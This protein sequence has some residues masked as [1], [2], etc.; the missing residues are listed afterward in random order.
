MNKAQFNKKVLRHAFNTKIDFDDWLKNNDA[1]L[2]SYRR[3]WERGCDDKE[4]KDKEKSL[5]TL[6]DI[7]YKLHSAYRDLQNALDDMFDL[8]YSGARIPGKAL[9]KHEFK[10]LAIDFILD[11]SD[12]LDS[13]YVL[14]ED[15][16]E[17]LED[18]LDESERKDWDKAWEKYTEAFGDLE[19]YHDDIE[20]VL[21]TMFEPYVSDDPED[22]DDEE[23]LDSE[24]DEEEDDELDDASLRELAEEV[25]AKEERM[26]SRR[27]RTSSS[28]SP[29]SRSNPDSIVEA[30]R[31]YLRTNHLNPHTEQ[32][33]QDIAR[34][35]IAKGIL[36]DSEAEICALGEEY[37]RRHG[38][39]WS[40]YYTPAAGG[41][42]TPRT[43]LKDHP[44]I[45]SIIR[46][47]PLFL[48]HNP[49][50]TRSL[51]NDS[52]MKSRIQS[53]LDDDSLLAGDKKKYIHNILK[54]YSG[55]KGNLDPDLFA[56]DPWVDDPDAYLQDDED[57]E[58]D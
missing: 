54:D 56:M 24:N 17:R 43:A 42:E 15:Y 58:D 6:D 52:G 20:S 46:S 13:A 21:E 35:M 55:R 26:H 50:L 57:E 31:K 3:E 47:D 33:F 53:I 49:R 36:P 29:K 16:E 22:E 5:D 2:E 38:K 25:N 34:I 28:G 19:K 48:Q 30:I 9:T 51:E 1:L 18:K 39:R 10:S 40:D 4:W 37:A 32:E 8:P 27:R 12:R 7:I 14:C 45:Q 44:L 23:D 11:Y 41:S